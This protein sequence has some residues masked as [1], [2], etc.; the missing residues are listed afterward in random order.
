MPNISTVFLAL[1][2]TASC[3]A[4]SAQTTVPAELTNA[5][6]SFPSTGDRRVELGATN[7][8]GLGGLDIQASSGAAMGALQQAATPEAGGAFKIREVLGA[9]T[10]PMM[11]ALSGG[12]TTNSF[13][14][15]FGSG[16]SDATPPVQLLI[17]TGANVGSMTS[18]MSSEQ[19]AT[20]VKIGP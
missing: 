3:G 13:A 10:S 9:S 4:A 8:N 6:Q 2:A 15:A 14:A 1:V 12:L 7:R 5:L 19:P 11:G 17:G 20:S 18:S 16:S